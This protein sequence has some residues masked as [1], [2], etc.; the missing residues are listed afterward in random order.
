MNTVVAAAIPGITKK[1]Y[2]ISGTK[3]KQGPSIPFADPGIFA[4]GGGVLARLLE[5]SSVNVFF[6]SFTPQLILSFTEGIQWLFQRKL[7]F[8]KVSERVGSNI[9][10]G[11][12]GGGGGYSTFLKKPIKY[13]IFQGA[14]E[15]ISHL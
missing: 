3:T 13:V 5:H 6:F 8:S 14:P 12:G 1:A 9:F 15:P 10:R 11:G 2:L 7:L 4:R